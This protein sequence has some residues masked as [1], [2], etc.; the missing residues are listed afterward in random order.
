MMRNQRGLITVDFLFALVL[1]LGFSGILFT[2]TLTLSVASITQYITFASARNYSAAHVTPEAQIARGQMKY[3]ELIA[4]PVFR[5]FFR[6]GWFAVDAQANIGDHTQRIPGFQQAAGGTNKFWGV[7]TQ[8]VAKI[9]DF[10]IPFF[11]STTSEGDGSGAGFRAYIGSYL[12]REPT[13]EECLEF[14]KARWVAIRALSHSG[15]ASYSSGTSATG[16]YPTADDGC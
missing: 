3:Q 16:Y 4:S 13:T 7:G 5:S 8:F 2:V 14:T 6:N 11:G 12:N 15:G 10:Q 1:I 9:L